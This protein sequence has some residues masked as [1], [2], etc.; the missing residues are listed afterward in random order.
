VFSREV[1]VVVAYAT[2]AVV[3]ATR[4]QQGH[5]ARIAAMAAALGAVLQAFSLTAWVLYA[6]DAHFLMDFR[7]RHGVDDVLSW[8]GV[9]ALVGVLV[10]VLMGR[11]ARPGRR[12]A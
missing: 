7:T 5:W 12:P 3:C 2:A 11:G 9:L 1:L 4:W 10:A 8:L 6:N